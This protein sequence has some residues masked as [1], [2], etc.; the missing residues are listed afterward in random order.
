MNVTL[1]APKYPKGTKFTTRGKN[2]QTC[3]VIDWHYIVNSDGFVLKIRYVAQHSFMSQNL[4]EEYPE[5]S[6]DMGNPQIPS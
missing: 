4:K 5:T 6:I 1:A 3:I 2:P